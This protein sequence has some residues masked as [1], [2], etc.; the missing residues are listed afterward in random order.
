M[1]HLVP[2]CQ[3]IDGEQTSSL[4]SSTPSYVN[5]V[6]GNGSLAVRLERIVLEGSVR[7]HTKIDTDQF[8]SFLLGSDIKVKVKFKFLCRQKTPM[9][10]M[11]KCS[12][13]SISLINTQLTF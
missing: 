11:M 10:T 4:I 13:V 7:S 8:P 6:L 5:H 3:S 1:W 12:D 9:Q 2:G